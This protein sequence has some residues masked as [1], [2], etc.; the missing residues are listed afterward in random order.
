MPGPDGVGGELDFLALV[1]EGVE[2]GLGQ[3]ALGGGVAAGAGLVEF[4]VHVLLPERGEGGDFPGG[5]AGEGVAF[6]LGEDVLAGLFEHGALAAEAVADVVIFQRTAAGAVFLPGARLDL[7][8]G[9][10]EFL[11]EAVARIGRVFL[12]GGLLAGDAE[13]LADGGDFGKAAVEKS[14]RDVAAVGGKGS[15]RPGLSEARAMFST[16]VNEAA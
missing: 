16:R 1:H 10:D 9:L 13:E 15:S 5:D 11:L 2:A 12:V 14:L 7:L 3:A 4:A 6:E 8:D